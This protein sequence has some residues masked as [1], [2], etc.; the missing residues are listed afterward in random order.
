MALRKLNEAF[1]G[2]RGSLFAA[3]LAAPLGLVAFNASTSEAVAQQQTVSSYITQN[4]TPL[5]YAA[6]NMETY[7]QKDGGV[8]IILHYHPWE[9]G[10]S[11]E[12][13]GNAFVEQFK[14]LG[15]SAAFTI[16]ENDVPG[17]SIFY[18]VHETTQGPINPNDAW[19]M[20]ANIIQQNNFAKG[21][22]TSELSALELTGTN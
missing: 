15:S 3:A 2:V 7:S 9:G 20:I 1:S 19:R 17:V 22:Q 14:A 21:I 18:S 8:G 12:E 4:G 6:Q 10:K 5:S 13:I 11:A 16:V